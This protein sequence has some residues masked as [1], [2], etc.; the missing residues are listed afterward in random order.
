[1]NIGFIYCLTNFYMPGIC[2]IGRTDRSPSQRCKELSGS[3]SAPA[4]FELQFYVE[5]NDSVRV[6]RAIHL[7]FLQQRINERREFFSCK[8]VDAYEWLR[9]NTEIFTEYLDG[10]VIF[11]LQK[12]SAVITGGL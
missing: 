11:E 8:P 12:P 10:G 2:K 9:C 1:M 7:A 3:T 4:D 5:V 6:E